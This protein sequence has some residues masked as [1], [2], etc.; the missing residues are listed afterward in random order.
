MRMYMVHMHNT[1][2][3]SVSILA[4]GILAWLDL[5]QGVTVFLVIYC[6]VNILAKEFWKK[7]RKWAL[8]YSKPVPGHLLYV[9][10]K[11]IIIKRCRNYYPILLMRLREVSF[12]PKIWVSMEQT[13]NLNPGL[14]ASMLYLCITSPCQSEKQDYICEKYWMIFFSNLPFH[15]KYRQVELFLTSFLV[16]GGAVFPIWRLGGYKF[17]PGSRKTFKTL[18]INYVGYL[19]RSEWCLGSPL[20]ML[21]HIKVAHPLLLNCQIAVGLGEP[22]IVLMCFLAP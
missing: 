8:M 17:R 3:F 18:F 13:W 19:F 22:L 12:L 6:S 5:I 9:I 7:R 21:F 1:K 10:L 4:W 14:P 2:S 16:S 11:L 20:R 15:P